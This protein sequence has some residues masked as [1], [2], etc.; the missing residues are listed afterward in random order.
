SNGSAFNN[1][2]APDGS[3]VAFLQ[4]SSSISQAVNLA[5]GLYSLSFQAAQRPGN[6]QTFQV[7]VD[8]AVVA[9][10]TPAD[11]QFAL[12]T[13]GHF[14]ITT[15]GSHTIQ[16]V[17]TNAQGDNTAFLDQIQMSIAQPLVSDQRGL[18]RIRGTAVDLGAFEVSGPLVVDTL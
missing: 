14:L 6:Q 13:T 15:A 2:T 9:T 7:E 5:A 16:F 3:Q 10:V 11:S 8:G 1:P 4:Q 17:G 12:Y 18:P